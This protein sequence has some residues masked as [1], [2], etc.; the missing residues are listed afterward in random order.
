MTKAAWKAHWHV[1]LILFS[2]LLPP[3]LIFLLT[4][5]SLFESAS[6]L[7]FLVNMIISILHSLYVS[8]VVHGGYF[9]L[10]FIWGFILAT[11]IQTFISKNKKAASLLPLQ[12]IIVSLFVLISLMIIAVLLGIFSTLL[13]PIVGLEFILLLA[14]IALT[15]KKSKAR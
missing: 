11:S 4:V 10:L 9:V 3:V 5:P 15:Y 6:F 13:K 2:F 7:L 1:R 8:L 14:L 12:S